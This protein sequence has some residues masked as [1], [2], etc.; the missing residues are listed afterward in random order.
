MMYMGEVMKLYD[1][2]RY[3]FD[4]EHLFHH[5]TDEKERSK[6]ESKTF[7]WWKPKFDAVTRCWY[8]ERHDGM[9]FN[10][11]KFFEWEHQDIWPEYLKNLED[12]MFYEHSPA[13]YVAW[14]KKVVYYRSVVVWNEAEKRIKVEFPDKRP[15]QLAKMCDAEVQNYFESLKDGIPFPRVGE[16]HAKVL[17]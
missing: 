4:E 7:P 8:L 12:G 10:F 11:G 14:L 1:K 3:S 16:E 15:D 17:H 13:F 5:F 2:L 6:L 9:I